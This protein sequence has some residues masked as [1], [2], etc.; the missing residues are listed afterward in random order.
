MSGRY[1]IVVDMQNDFLDGALG[2]AEA[3]AILPAVIEKVWEFDGK[4]LFTYD[5]HGEGYLDTQEGRRLPVAHCVEG[6][7]GW[8]L[9]DELEDTRFRTGGKAFTKNTFG[10]RGLAEYLGAEDAVSP[11]ESVELVGL[12]TD[13]CV[14]SNALLIKAFLPE[15]EIIVDPSC[16]AGTSPEAHECALRAMAACQITI[17]HAG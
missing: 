11:V 3:L 14:I 4:V 10:A 5:T 15:A 1:L 7:R 12:C 8:R 17:A 13:V 16:C 9:P 6:T 2:S